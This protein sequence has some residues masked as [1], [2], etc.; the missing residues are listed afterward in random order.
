M[1]HY[2]KDTDGSYKFDKI[3]EGEF[4]NGLLNGLGRILNCQ[5]E[6]QL[7]YWTI[8]D[9][10]SVPNH[11]WAWYIAKGQFHKDNT[12]KVYI[13][14]K[15]SNKPTCINV[16]N[17]NLDPRLRKNKEVLKKTQNIEIDIQVKF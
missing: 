4:Q 17:L 7:G 13:G 5:G 10:V 16:K 6:C 11:S 12:Q 1:I 15:N 3:L 9:G 2:T 8:S 14:T